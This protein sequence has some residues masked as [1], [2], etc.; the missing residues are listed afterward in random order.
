VNMGPTEEIQNLEHKLQAV[1][2]ARSPLEDNIREMREFTDRLNK[3]YT[4]PARRTPRGPT[5]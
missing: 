5:H 2:Q 3:F 1:M 4:D